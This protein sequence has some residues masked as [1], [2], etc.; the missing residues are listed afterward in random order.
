MSADEF[1]KLFNYMEKR[2][3]ELEA[4]LDTRF[5]AIDKRIDH[6]IN[7]I[8]NLAKRVEINDEERIVMAHQLERLDQWVHQLAEKIGVE[9]SV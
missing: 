7:V 6:L 1:T 8:D 9:L 3:S 5:D 2:F 4:K